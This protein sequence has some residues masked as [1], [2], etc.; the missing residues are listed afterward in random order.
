MELNVVT[1]CYREETANVAVDTSIEDAIK[2]P[3]TRERLM[4]KFLDNL[5][6][7]IDPG[8]IDIMTILGFLYMNEEEGKNFKRKHKYEKYSYSNRRRLKE[9]KRLKIGKLIENKKEKTIIQN[10]TLKDKEVE[11]NKFNKK[12]MNNDK[13]SE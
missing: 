1:K 11:L 4:K 6:K 2:D 9:T 12:T 5:I 10:K 7:A 8:D 3:I 13:F